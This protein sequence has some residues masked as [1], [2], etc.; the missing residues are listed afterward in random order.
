M[1]LPNLY[2]EGLRYRVEVYPPMKARIST[3]PVDSRMSA[4]EAGHSIVPS[5]EQNYT[6]DITVGGRRTLQANLLQ[7]DIHG[8]DFERTRGQPVKDHPIVVVAFQVANSLLRCLRAIGQA[9]EIAVLDREKSSYSVQFL[10]D[11]G[12]E[13]PENPE[14]FRR[15]YSVRYSGRLTRVTQAVWEKA[16]SLPFD[17]ESSTWDNLLLGAELL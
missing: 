6:D 2:I 13:L 14:L 8:H 10:D 5:E 7:L 4:V 3:M 9:P 16:K 17:Y 12:Q 11:A 15:G 1:T